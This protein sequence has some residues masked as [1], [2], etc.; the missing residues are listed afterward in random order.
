MVRK[1][2][3]ELA[4]FSAWERMSTEFSDLLRA[5]DPPRLVEVPDDATI[6]G[7]FGYLLR[8][9]AA[10]ALLDG[11]V[12]ATA[13]L[14]VD[15]LQ[16]DFEAS[17]TRVRNDTAEGKSLVMVVLKDP[18]NGAE[19]EPVSQASLQLSVTDVRPGY[20]LDGISMILIA[21]PLLR[22]W[23]DAVADVFISREPA[24]MPNFSKYAVNSAALA[25]PLD[26]A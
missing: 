10:R 15:E 18:V 16:G 4:T 26:V 11:E 9:S 1:L 7:L 19:N 24:N 23:R 22:P 2:K 5:S 20:V 25:M 6:T 21:A 3:E 14:S 17:A 8:R 12:A 13:N